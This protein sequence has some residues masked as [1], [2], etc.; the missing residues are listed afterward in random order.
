MLHNLGIDGRD[1]AQQ[2]RDIVVGMTRKFVEYVKSARVEA[3][4]SLTAL[5][6]RA[7]PDNMQILMTREGYPIVPRIV[8]EKELRKADWEKLLRAYVAQHYCEPLFLSDM[9]T[10]FNRP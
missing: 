4:E 8:M 7:E 6:T 10:E 9:Q 3:T 1:F 2:H 5:Q